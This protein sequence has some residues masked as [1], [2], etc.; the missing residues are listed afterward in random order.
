MCA[1]ARV[2]NWTMFF[3]T[4]CFATA[5]KPET[6]LQRKGQHPP[7]FKKSKSPFFSCPWKK[8][9]SQCIFFLPCVIIFLKFIEWLPESLQLG[10]NLSLFKEPLGFGSS[11]LGCCRRLEQRRERGISWLWR[12]LFLAL[13]CTVYLGIPEFHIFVCPFC[14]IIVLHF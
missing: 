11:Q 7:V 4:Q 13:W 10:G 9:K 1:R 3:Y 5:V 8:K 12:C 6:E 2:A 14:K